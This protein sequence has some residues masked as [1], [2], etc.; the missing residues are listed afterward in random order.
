MTH[1]H[2]LNA[3]DLNAD[4]G[5]GATNDVAL[6]EIVSSASIA[7]GAHAGND[8]LMHET[9]RQAAQR[10]VRIGAHP[11]YPDRKNFGRLELDLPADEVAGRV[12]EQLERF[13]EA[14]HTADAQTSY[15]KLHGALYNRAASDF[16]FSC[17]IFER[18]QQMQPQLAIMA[19]DN[20][21]QVKAAR[22]VGLG[23]I[24]EAFADRRYSADGKLVSRTQPGA[25]IHDAASAVTQALAI[26]RDRR[27][28]TL[29]NQ[30]I[31]SGAT[32]LCLH[33]DNAQALTLARRIRDALKQAGITIRAL[34]LSPPA[35]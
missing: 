20:S 26:V 29:D 9:I 3:M 6:L 13:L 14:A 34:P 35:L 10:H 32:S 25:V 8:D 12:A 17:R 30:T 18:I 31:A 11:G 16:D 24:P 33:G 1:D 4:L 22:H 21:S 19:L 2:A 5:E 15:V 28:T 23:Y 7:C 27:I